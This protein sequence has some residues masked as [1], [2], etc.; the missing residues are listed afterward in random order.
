MKR[1]GIAF[2]VVLII[3]L[4]SAEA[5]KLTTTIESSKLTTHAES[6]PSLGAYFVLQVDVPQAILK[7]KTT[8]HAFL[9]FYVDVTSR[10]VDGYTESTPVFEI[11]ALSASFSGQVDPTK[12]APQLI[13]TSRPVAAGQN[14]RVQIDIAEFIRTYVKNPSKNHGLIIGSLTG[15]RAGVFSIKANAFGAG[16]PAR[17]TYLK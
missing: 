14:R 17:I 9:E 10:E 13:A 8:N 5:D 1:I 2:A 11:Y 4:S 12:F 3:W 7:A 16:I 15:R 6:N